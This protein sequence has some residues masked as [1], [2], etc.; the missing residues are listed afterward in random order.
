MSEKTLPFIWEYGQEDII[1]KVQSYFYGKGIAVLM[2]TR[3]EEG[4]LEP[5]SELTVNLPHDTLKPGEG[6][7]DGNFTKEKLQFMEQHKLGKLLPG[8]GYSGFVTYQKVAFDLEQLS[9]FDQK[10]VEEFKRLCGL[11]ESKETKKKKR[12]RER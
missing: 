4:E 9:K 11:T 6:Y 10:G 12:G 3:G 7:I 2:Y 5:F 1:L 8:K